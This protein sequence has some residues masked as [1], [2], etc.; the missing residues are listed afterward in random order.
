MAPPKGRPSP[1]KVCIH[2]DDRGPAQGRAERGRD[3]RRQHPGFQWRGFGVLYSGEAIGST[4]CFAIKVIVASALFKHTSEVELA[5]LERVEVG[6]GVLDEVGGE[7]HC[8][9]CLTK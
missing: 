1:R 3:L 8:G 4:L 6:E 7:P 2:V 9:D 5:L